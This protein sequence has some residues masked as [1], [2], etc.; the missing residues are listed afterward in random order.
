MDNNI[1]TIKRKIPVKYANYD[2]ESYR[3]ALSSERIIEL[4]RHDKLECEFYFSEAERVN[5]LAYDQLRY[6]TINLEKVCAK[7][8]E[9]KD[10]EIIVQLTENYYGSI[11]KEILETNFN[12]VS[13]QMRAISK[14]IDGKRCILNIITFDIVKCK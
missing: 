11:L 14:I 1:Y 10:D 5:Y 3:E 4:M 6:Q 9:I 2:E 7:I 12:N 8:I 13:A